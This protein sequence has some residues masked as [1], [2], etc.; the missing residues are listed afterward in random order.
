MLETETAQRLRHELVAAA[1]EGREDDAEVVRDLG[2]GL[3]VDGHLHDLG[4][5]GLVGL[6]AHDL[7]HAARDG[8][9]E[10]TGLEA[11][12]DVD[13]LHLFGNGV[14]V[15]GR[16]LGAVGPVDLIAVVFLGVVA[17]RDVDAGGAAVM[18]HGERK[19]RGGTQRVEQPHVDA[20]CGHDAGGLDG[21]IAAVETAVV[22]DGDALAHRLLAFGG[23][24]VGK[25]LG[26][27]ADDMDVHVV[28]TD[29]H[30]AA[31]SGGAELQRGEKAA[32]DL[33]LVAGDRVEFSPLL[34]GEGR[35]VQPALVLFFIIPHRFLLLL[36]L[37]R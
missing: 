29:L 11:G 19:L 14:R 18:D 27:V 21:E 33:L 31:Q 10:G 35:A 3:L 6:C 36:L 4:K 22:V 25:G 12:K 7:D 28:K 34:L 15:A 26:R 30:R 1:V 8:L 24:D 16:Q 5:E 23:D 17:G 13:L 32:F 9:V 2:D 37:L 20:V